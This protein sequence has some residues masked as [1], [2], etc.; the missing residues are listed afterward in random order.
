MN[1]SA[2]NT[3]LP[4]LLRSSFCLRSLLPAI[5]L[6]S[7]PAFCKAGDVLVM[8]LRLV[9]VNKIS[10]RHYKISAKCSS[11]A[12]RRLFHLAGP[13][14]T[15]IYS[16]CPHLLAC[17]CLWV[18]MRYSLTSHTLEAEWDHFPGECVNWVGTELCPLPLALPGST[19]YAVRCHLLFFGFHN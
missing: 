10:A 13:H 11:A 17:L 3:H 8:R 18:W 7:T 16:G 5:D 9:R 1:E 12:K 14:V 2:N 4:S 6:L 15:F 19:L